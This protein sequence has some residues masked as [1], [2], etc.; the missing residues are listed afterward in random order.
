[1]NHMTSIL[2]EAYILRKNRIPVTKLICYRDSKE[3]FN[4]VIW[5]GKKSD[6]WTV[7]IGNG[8]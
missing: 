1:M 6:L 4:Q 8:A 2:L 7:Y 3:E 5:G